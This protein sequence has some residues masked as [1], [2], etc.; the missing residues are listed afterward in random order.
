M[1]GNGRVPAVQGVLATKI[2]GIACTLCSVCPHATQQ[3]MKTAAD[4]NLAFFMM[5]FSL[6]GKGNPYIF[7]D[8]LL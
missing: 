6:Q 4:N 5:N 8:T 2:A 1:P 7:I 3:N